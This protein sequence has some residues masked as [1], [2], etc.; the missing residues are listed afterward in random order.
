MYENKNLTTESKVS[1]N[2]GTNY[3]NYKNDKEGY[4]AKAFEILI[5]YNIISQDQAKKLISK[6]KIEIPNAQ[7]I[8]ENFKNQVSE[9]NS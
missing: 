1:Y 5:K 2:I 8:L 9:K 6:K 3:L 7:S 4:N